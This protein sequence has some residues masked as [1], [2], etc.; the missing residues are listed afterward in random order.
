MLDGVIAELQPL[1]GARIQR[2][3]VVDEGELVV[4]LR[5]PG[6]TLRLLICARPG[7]SR[8]H[9]VERRPAKR[10][11]PGALQGGL[12]RRMEG[13]PL[14]GLRAEGPLVVLEVPGTRVR[15]RLGRG[16]IEV[17]DA[18]DLVAPPIVSAAVPDHF[19]LSEHLAGDL[20][21]RVDR[22]LADRLRRARL[23][24]VEAAL[25]KNKRLLAKLAT[26]LER[27]ER[28]REDARHGELLK[29]ALHRARRGMTSIE[30]TDWSSGAQVA[31]PLDPSL[32]PRANLERFFQRAKRLERGRPKV[33]ARVAE[34]EER[35]ARLEE[36]R[37]RLRE[38]SLQ[39]LSAEPDPFDNGVRG[40]TR[41]T[42]SRAEGGVTGPGPRVRSGQD[43]AERWARRFASADG[44]TIWVGRGA[45]ANDRLTFSLARGHDLWLHARGVP[46]AH[47]LLRLAKGETPPQEAL[48][49]AAHLAVFY[50]GSKGAAKAEVLYTEARFVKKTKGAAPGAVSVSKDKT[51]LL[52]VEEE[53]LKRLLAGE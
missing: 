13:R 39:Q 35:V 53:R 24:P 44:H 29:T 15:A 11:P 23:A 46:G 33:A 10:A 2:V 19:P 34:I 22:D 20:A 36:E 12:R 49:D 5:V 1:V 7:T 32:D 9:L 3:D 31:V 8:V 30:V 14:W 27:L 50:S 40:S 4:E 21:A 48:L 6:R 42:R 41:G 17:E 26:D 37:L 28:H 47:V 45:A 52:R 18:A 16:T 38:A 43:P 51:L 25:K